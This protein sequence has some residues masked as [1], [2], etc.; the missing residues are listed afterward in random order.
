MTQLQDPRPNDQLPFIRR[1]A[2]TEAPRLAQLHT[3]TVAYGYRAIF[4]PNSQAPT[5]NSL[6][7]AWQDLLT[8]KGVAVFIA[9]DSHAIVGSIAIVPDGSV[10][11]GLLLK[12]L[13]VLPSKWGQGIGSALHDYALETAARQGAQRINLWVLDAN[14]RARGMYE[15][16]GWLLKPGWELPNEPPSIIDV[17]YERDLATVAR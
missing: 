5:P 3:E 12:R 15:R 17:L 2:P 8:E 14:L 13:H 4:D 7:A 6:T 16:R 11:S 10:P 1:A 9:E